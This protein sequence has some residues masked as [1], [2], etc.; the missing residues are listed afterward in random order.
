ML[1]D[2]FAVQSE[3]RIFCKLAQWADVTPAISILQLPTLR[4]GVT[5]RADFL[6]K[7]VR[8]PLLIAAAFKY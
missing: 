2:V 8:D 7:E 3:S 5:R 1:I 6:P 4:I